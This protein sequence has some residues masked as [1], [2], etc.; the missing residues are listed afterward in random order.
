[1]NPAEE[2]YEQWRLDYRNN[3]PPRKQA[4]MEGWQAAIDYLEDQNEYN[5]DGHKEDASIR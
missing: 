5:R 4:F 1:M 3:L 2:A